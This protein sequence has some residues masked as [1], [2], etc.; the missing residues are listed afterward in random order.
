MG[1]FIDDATL[2]SKITGTKMEDTI[3][4]IN[5]NEEL[6]IVDPNLKQSENVSLENSPQESNRKKIKFSKFQPPNGSISDVKV[7]MEPSPTKQNSSY[8]TNVNTNR[9]KRGLSSINTSNFSSQKPYLSCATSRHYQAGSS[10]SPCQ[11]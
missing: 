3:R 5:S 4:S 1:G 10:E 6:M 8:N 9:S 11:Y 7:Q 2:L